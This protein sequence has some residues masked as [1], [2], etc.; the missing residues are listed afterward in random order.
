MPDEYNWQWITYI[1]RIK[2]LQK[3]NLIRKCLSYTAPSIRISLE[4]YTEYFYLFNFTGKVQYGLKAISVKS[5][6]NEKKYMKM[7]VLR[8][9]SSFRFL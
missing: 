8:S 7:K 1:A 6:I 9:L 5:V 4:F 2:H 3:Q